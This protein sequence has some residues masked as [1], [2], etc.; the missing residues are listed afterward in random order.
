MTQNWPTVLAPQLQLLEAI[1]VRTTTGLTGLTNSRFPQNR[2]GLEV[3]FF[4]FLMGGNQTFY[5][6]TAGHCLVPLTARQPSG[7]NLPTGQ[8]ARAAGSGQRDHLAYRMTS[9]TRL[10]GCLLAPHTGYH[11]STNPGGFYLAL[12]VLPACWNSWTPSAA[13]TGRTFTPDLCPAGN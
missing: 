13:Y 5:D 11:P 7:I 2:C 3:V 12:L 6:G 8:S 4:F 10:G 1:R 9:E